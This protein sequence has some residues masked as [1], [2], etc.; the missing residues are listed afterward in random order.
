MWNWRLF[1]LQTGEPVTDITLPEPS[2]ATWDTRL[3]GRGPGRHIFQLYGSG[4]SRETVL[5]RTRGNKYVLAQM[6]GES[7]VC[8]AGVIQRRHYRRRSGSRSLEISSLELRGAYLNDRMLHGVDNYVAGGTILTVTNKSLSGA[9]RAVLTSEIF[10][11]GGVLPIDLPADGSGTFSATWAH[12][13]RLK[14][15]DYLAQIEKAGCEIFFRPY[16]NG[17][18]NLR[19]ETIVQDKVQFGDTT[20]LD[21]DAPNSPVLDLDIIE[22]YVREMTGLLG[23]GKGGVSAPTA[24]AGDISTAGISIRDTWRNYPDISGS[25]LQA[26][27]NS[28]FNVTKEPT[29]QWDFGLRILPDGPGF[30]L[31]GRKLSLSIEDDEFAADGP[32]AMRVIA[33]SG[34]LGYT[35][36]P[37]VQYGD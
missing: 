36:K 31:P 18:G 22:D 4:L 13:E 3:T 7:L 26:A 2:Q 35:V 27:V 20:S 15:E 14:A 9:V 34:D 12:N 8:Y 1:T 24:Y 17:S 25:R 30:A 21:A 29:E 11:S 37:E 32:H 33:L 19:F 23:F 6:W 10:G 5:A 28:D 16:I